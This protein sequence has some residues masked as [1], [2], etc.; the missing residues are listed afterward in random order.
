M[1]FSEMEALRTYNLSSSIWALMSRA[2]RNSTRF[3]SLSDT[4]LSYDR[5]PS[6]LMCIDLRSRKFLCERRFRRRPNNR[7]C[8]SRYA[9]RYHWQRHLWG[10]YL[11]AVSSCF[12]GMSRDIFSVL[13]GRVTSH[14]T[15]QAPYPFAT[16]RVISLTIASTQGCTFSGLTS[17]HMKHSASLSRACSQFCKPGIM[18]GLRG[19]H[20]MVEL[21]PL[22]RISGSTKWTDLKL[23]WQN[24]GWLAGLMYTLGR[25]WNG[26][27]VQ[28]SSKIESL[29]AKSKQDGF[30]V[31]YPDSLALCSC[32]E[33]PE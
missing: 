22:D 20:V 25:N 18:H 19:V 32:W 30:I 15:Y 14:V 7:V 13:R 17:N 31:L 27:P 28:S 8:Q 4:A 2:S 33:A 26:R 24:K 3:R 23:P 6:S 16:G 12:S 5:F 1:D 21:A 9:N 29:V 11:L 10:P